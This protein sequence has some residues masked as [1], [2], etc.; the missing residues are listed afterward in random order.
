[1]TEK[2]TNKLVK[3]KKVEKKINKTVQYSDYIKE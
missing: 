1:M 3:R 2:T